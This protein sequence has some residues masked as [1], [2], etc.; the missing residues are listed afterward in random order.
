LDNLK[1]QDERRYKPQLIKIIGT[2]MMSLIRVKALQQQARR[3]YAIANKGPYVSKKKEGPVDARYT[4]IKDMLYSAEAQ[5]VPIARVPPPKETPVHTSQEHPDLI[6]K[7]TIERAWAHAK[8]KEASTTMDE[9]KRKYRMMRL[10]MEE[11]ERT[12]AR[13]FAEAK[14]NPILKKTEDLVLFPTQLRV[15]TETPPSV[16]LIREEEA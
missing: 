9:L 1:L 10:A 5:P 8:L 3:G 12:D 2:R 15:P 11:L 13:L 4:R 14:N 16:E 6:M 7:D